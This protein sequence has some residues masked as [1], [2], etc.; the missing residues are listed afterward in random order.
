M[1]DAH[2]FNA[3][4]CLAAANDMSDNRIPAVAD[5]DVLAKPPGL[6][7]VGQKRERGD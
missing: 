1:Q 4:V 5:P 3:E 6:R 7:M 2:D